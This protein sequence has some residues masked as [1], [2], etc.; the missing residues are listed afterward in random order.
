METIA[1]ACAVCLVVVFA[2]AAVGK[3]RGASTFAAFVDTVKD[4]RLVPERWARGCAR[5]LVAGETAAALLLLTA[6]LAPRAGTAGFILAAAL[7]AVFTTAVALT[8]ARRTGVRCRCFG[9][10][11]SPLGARHAVRNGVLTVVALTGAVLAPA[12]VR[13]RPAEALLAV[14]AGTLAGA[15]AVVWDDIVGLFHPVSP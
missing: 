12:V 9:A 4:L 1:A 15:L 13:V 8:V 11:A 2:T 5:L 14:C 3:V 10:S 7:L 6:P